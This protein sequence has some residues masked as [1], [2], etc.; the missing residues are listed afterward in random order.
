MP[1]YKNLKELHAAFASG[2]LNKNDYVKERRNKSRKRKD[3][4]RDEN[5]SL[6]F[7]RRFQKFS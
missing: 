4:R 7:E 6:F 2:E 5:S 3:E 1:K